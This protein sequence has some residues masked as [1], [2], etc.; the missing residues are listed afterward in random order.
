[1]SNRTLRQ[2]G[3]AL[4]CLF[5]AAAGP[6]AKSGSRWL[7]R[8]NFYRTIASLPPV[9]EEPG[10]SRAVQQHARYMVKHDVVKHSEK[11]HDSWATADG[12][13][14]AA[15][16]NLAG[17]TSPS[18]PDTWAIDIWMQA[19]FHAVGMLDPALRQVGFGIEHERRGRIQTA[20]GLDVIRGRSTSISPSIPYPIVWPADGTS[21]PLSTGT[22]EYPNPLTSC[23]GYKEP[24][25]L[26]LIVQIGSGNDVPRVTGSWMSDGVEALEHCVFDESTY[27]NR[28]AAEQQLGR[29]VLASR[30]AIVVIPR[31]PLQPGPSYRVV[32]DV[33]GSRIDWTFSVSLPVSSS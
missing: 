20:A 21:V 23:E 17:S 6:N 33:N 11:T 16:S 15:A 7:N 27:R 19:P 22:A 14:A 28:N 10:L 26:P 5:T 12:A 13:Q 24:T 4:L 25:G 18:E 1:M 9:V 8:L 30:N 3:I 31:K 2:A 32:I 29:S